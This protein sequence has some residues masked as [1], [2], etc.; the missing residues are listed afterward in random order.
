[1]VGVTEEDGE[2]GWGQGQGQGRDQD[3]DQGLGLEEGVGVVWEC[4]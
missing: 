4:L 2:E 3:R 1:L